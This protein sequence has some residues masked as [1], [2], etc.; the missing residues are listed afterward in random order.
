MDAEDSPCPDLL[1][2]GSGCG[3]FA[4]CE[5]ETETATCVCDSGWIQSLDFAVFAENAEE[6][7]CNAHVLTIK[8]LYGLGAL[9][10]LI[11]FSVN[12]AVIQNREQFCRHLPL[13]AAF[14][15]TAVSMGYKVLA[16][17]VAH[18]GNQ[19]TYTILISGMFL[20]WC[21]GAARFH[22][23]WCNFLENQR[24]SFQPDSGMVKLWWR[25]NSK[26]VLHVFYYTDFLVCS[27]FPLLLL[28]ED[29]DTKSA[30]FRLLFAL[31]A[32]RYL[33]QMFLAVLVYSEF[34]KM[35]RPKSDTSRTLVSSE[36]SNLTNITRTFTKT[37][38][39]KQT[40]D[41]KRM[42]KVIK[43]I[44]R[45]KNSY[46]TC[47]V[48]AFLLFVAPVISTKAF[49]IWP[50]GLVLLNL[51]SQTFAIYVAATGYQRLQR[52]NRGKTIALCNLFRTVKPR[53]NP[54]DLSL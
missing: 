39:Q 32:F 4:S 38:Q 14:I 40:E 8:T 29:P 37:M 10:A 41:R 17:D 42:N 30:L 33:V 24:Q 19:L 43:R 25:R 6:I 5:V 50:Y 47:Y 15:A 23:K 3:F 31:M 27:S 13:L 36:M 51:A 16:F 21:Y 26:R 45:E 22:L 12:L 11:T 34:I 53:S 2:H 44:R 28:V 7:V 20:M 9:C 54:N 48:A 35:T 46:F 52:K 1:P 49:L 18:V